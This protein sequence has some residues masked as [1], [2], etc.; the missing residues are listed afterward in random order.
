VNNPTK[1]DYETLKDIAKSLQRQ[2]V[3]VSVPDLIILAPKNDPFY[4]GAPSQR[5]DAEWFAGIYNQLG[6]LSRLHLRRV[7]YRILDLSEMAR[8]LP[9]SLTTIDTHPDGR[10]EEI[11]FDTYEN[12][13]RCWEFL[14][15]AA[16][17]ARYLNL[18][19]LDAF[20]D[21]RA[22]ESSFTFNARW[23]KPGDWD[24]EDPNPG[25]KVT[26][27]W[28]RYDL[29]ELP[30]L[31]D[32]PYGL[33]DLPEFEISGYAVQQPYHIEIWVEKSEGQDVFLPL[34]WQY[35]LN[36]VPGVGDMSITTTYHFAERVRQAGRPA[37]LL[38]ISDFDPSGF[39]MPVA[40][41][42][43]LEHFVRNHGFDDLDITLEPVMLT[44]EQVRAY[45]LPPV[46][47]KS[48]D[49]RKEDWERQ[50]GGA[51]E[52]NAMFARDERIVAARRIVETAILKYYDTTLPHR[53]RQQRLSLE[54]A[55]AAE[56][57]V[58]IDQHADEWNILQSD[59]YE[60]YNEWDQTR[61]EFSQLIEPFREQIEAYRER[62]E[63]INRRGAEINSTV[64][65]DLAAI[66]LDLEN[67]YP[68][69]E[70]RQAETD[71][72]LYHSQ[73]DYWNQLRAYREHKLNGSADQPLW[74]DLLAAA[75]E[76]D[77]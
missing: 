49:A 7:H 56:R 33:A 77:D 68:L 44:A 8:R 50:H 20:I 13:N 74:L 71:G 28:P 26:G 45:N 36:F 61:Q 75:E 66:E 1:Y 19:P 37:K 17:S 65:E 21:E 40:V 24:Y 48:S 23:P 60:L 14:T 51:V 70:P 5:R 47:V 69:P 3:K 11:R 16:K 39:N 6:G 57:E 29:P 76:G 4:C 41:A 10:K 43:K 59:Y 27:D 42:R 67:D 18:V 38:Y 62:L 22:K 12:H 63:A 34:C 46:P 54:R 55:L 15:E 30:D 9:L 64:S 53:A 2:G 31:E 52:L 73:R 25:Y 35:K 32:L 72:L 58:V